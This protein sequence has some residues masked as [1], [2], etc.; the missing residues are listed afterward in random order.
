MKKRAKPRENWESTLKVPRETFENEDYQ[1]IFRK[2]K[3]PFND[4]T[5]KEIVKIQREYYAGIKLVNER[6]TMREV[7]AAMKK[8]ITHGKRY[9]ECLRSMDDRSREKLASLPRPFELLKIMDRNLEDTISVTCH[10]EYVLE[11][12]GYFKKNNSSG[13]PY[14][15]PIRAYLCAL[16]RIYEKASGKRATLTREPNPKYDHKGIG[17]KYKGKFLDFVSFCINKIPGHPQVKNTTLGSY[18][19]EALRNPVKTYGA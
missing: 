4:E 14:N 15:L 3:I 10:A 1:D 19:E 5:T 2:L 8:L 17:E 16:S 13:R 9:I 18:I 6:P 11:D 7:C 12:W